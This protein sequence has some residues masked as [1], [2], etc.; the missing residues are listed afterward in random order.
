ME[1][2][3]SLDEIVQELLWEQDAVNRKLD[4]AADIDTRLHHFEL[5]I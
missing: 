3:G 1:S 2:F 5:Q 4:E